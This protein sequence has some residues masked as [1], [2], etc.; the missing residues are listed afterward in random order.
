M[1]HATVRKMIQGVSVTECH[2]LWGKKG[3]KQCSDYWLLGVALGHF[4]STGHS[5]PWV[6]PGSAGR[7][8]CL[9][10]NQI[11]CTSLVEQC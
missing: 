10:I 9:V 5:D 11:H 6:A 7:V 1:G 2:P 8:S 3:N 4:A